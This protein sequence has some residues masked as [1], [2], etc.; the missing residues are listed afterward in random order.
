[1]AR[2]GPEGEAGWCGGTAPFSGDVKMVSPDPLSRVDVSL[3]VL[4]VGWLVS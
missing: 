1:M 2:S 3:P 4:R